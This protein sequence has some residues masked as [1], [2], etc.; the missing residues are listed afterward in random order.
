MQLTEQYIIGLFEVYLDE[1][2]HVEQLSEDNIVWVFENEFLPALTNTVNM[3][4]ES[5]KIESMKDR[6]TQ[7]TAS[8]L[9][10]SGKEGAS[11]HAAAVGST[12][13]KEKKQVKENALIAYTM[14]LLEKKGTRRLDAVGK[15]D[16][17]IN[18]D[19][20]VDT[21]DSYLKKRREKIGASIKNK[22]DVKEEEESEGEKN[23]IANLK[24][25]NKI[26]RGKNGPVI[27][28]PTRTQ[29]DSEDKSST[30]GKMSKVSEEHDKK[31][32]LR[33]KLKYL[34]KRMHDEDDKEVKK[35]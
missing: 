28:N 6:E 15:E 1:N 25:A 18:N 3:L 2:F 17:D 32:Y 4:N 24:G 8:K 20:K 14:N 34:R 29:Q 35:K 13:P 11:A 7:G 5:S 26:E 27:V 21:T 16:S 19:G 31:E 12:L 22:K 30:S 23:E 33:K 9:K 10:T